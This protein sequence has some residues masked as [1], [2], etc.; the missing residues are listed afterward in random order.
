MSIEIKQS[1]VAGSGQEI[2]IVMTANF[3]LDLQGRRKSAGRIE[4]ETVVLVDGKRHLFCPKVESLDH[5]VA[6][7]KLVCGSKAIGMSQENYDLYLANKRKIENSIRENN[8]ACD[9]HEASLMDVEKSRLEI[10]SVE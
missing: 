10:E 4:T 6:V 5:P 1:W 3:E 8:E 9:R 7:A 2:E